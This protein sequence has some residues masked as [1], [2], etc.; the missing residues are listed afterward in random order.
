MTYDVVLLDPPWPY[1]GDPNKNAAAG[2]HYELMDWEDIYNL[3]IKKYCNKKAWVCV[4]ATCPLLD[5]QLKVFERWGLHYRGVGFQWVKTRMDGGIISGQG[6]PCSFTKPTTELFL[7]GS[8]IK[9]GRPL[10]L[11]DHGMGQ[12]VLSPRGKHSEKPRAFQ[13]KI[14]ELFGDVPRIELFARENYPGWDAV[15]LELNGM[16]V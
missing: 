1:T 4:W 9:N 5:R 13:D 12:V 3:D 15:G 11:L 16:T 14:V 6:V 2:K 7:V 8:T 10:P